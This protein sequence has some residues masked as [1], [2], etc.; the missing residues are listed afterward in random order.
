[1][2]DQYLERLEQNGYLLYLRSGK[3]WEVHRR[4]LLP[5]VKVTEWTDRGER[6]VEYP[7]E[8]V[9]ATFPQNSGVYESKSG[10]IP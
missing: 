6:Q 5:R 7:K 2:S 1:M 10:S 4:G 8:L 9:F 3:T